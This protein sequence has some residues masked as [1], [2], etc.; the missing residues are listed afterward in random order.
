MPQQ[1]L[2]SVE[3]SFTKGLVTEFT[4]LNF[5]ENAAT[6]TNNCTYTLVGDVVRREGIDF[7]TNFSLS[8][9]TDRTNKAISNYKWNNAGGDSLTQ[10]V[11]Q[12]IGATLYFYKSS[13]ATAA[14]PL[15][16]TLLA[17]TV[18]VSSF[19]AVGGTFDPTVECQFADGN[20]YLVV[21]HPS[22]DPFYCTY[23]AG[24]ITG[25]VITIKTR[26]FE[27]VIENPL[28]A[29]NIRPP[30]PISASHVYNLENQ[31]WG[32]FWADVSTQTFGVGVPATFAIT[33]TS[34]SQPI[35]VG[36]SVT[37]VEAGNTA[38]MSGSVISYVGNVLTV[39]MVNKVGA[40]TFSS[41]NINP[42]DWYIAQWYNA[43][44]AYPANSDVWWNYRNSSN[45]FDP[46]TTLN[47]VTPGSYPAPKGHFV[48]SE[49]N[50]QRAGLINTN[51]ALMPDVTTT[52]RPRTGAWFQGRA[53]YT[54]ADS[55]VFVG[56][57]YHTWTENIYFSQIVQSGSDLGSCFQQNDPT[58]ST[59]FNLLPT[60]G[61]VIK[62][63]GC[64][65]IYK[66]FPLQNAMLVFAANGV[67]YL[68]GST[69]IGFAADDYTIVK[70]SSV[71]SISS[72]SFVDVQGL[73]MF[74]NEEG[75]YKVEPA[76][77]GTQLLNSP[78]HVNPLEVNPVTVGT[79]L[80]FYNNIPL[81]SK[82]FVKGAYHPIDYIVQ[83][84]YKSVNEVSVTD[85]Y[86][87][88]SILNYNVVNK[89]F[90]P[91][92]ITGTP[93]IHGVIYVEGPGGSNS[94][95]PVLKYFSSRLAGTYSYTFADEHD[96][97]F[98]DWASSGSSNYISSF[99][100]GYKLHGQGGRRFQIPYIY[101]Y[102]R[103]GQPVSY[104]IQSLWDYPLNTDS[105]KW[106]V[107]QLVNIN[108][109]NF[110]MAF[111]RHRLRGYGL[112]LQIKITSVDGQPF[113]IIGWALYETAN[114]GV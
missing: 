6:D 84:T 91:Y 41:W 50:K 83:W 11:V 81:Q 57:T 110:G 82:K 101:I 90:F 28:I 26:D 9:L 22:C 52:V 77:Q 97:S 67:W 18:S 61:G 39:Q 44:G 24:V 111:R 92:S 3:N 21:F 35:Q 104:Y 54:G 33:I 37:M 108:S 25:N 47:N 106:S 96:S 66:L 60:D 69:G 13:S 114:Q 64:G 94:P 88:D 85:R 55:S 68:T 51:P 14:A 17:S 29:N 75:I 89:A 43:V 12:Q 99:T 15:S 30:A 80:S 63:Q 72:A 42:T 5:P 38:N 71:R 46:K 20:G 8:A 100:T 112:V 36:D 93:F 40:G 65:S 45:V 113:D 16:T 62:I 32:H 102:S 34:S 49:F 27:G 56:T 107:N 59:L 98:V 76:K 48:L 73:P 103:L 109:P 10:V 79:I 78:L 2:S 7:E 19:V 86:Q 58:S 31:G 53:W 87:F 1:V 74:W 4:G 70:L 95:P 105:G 23:S